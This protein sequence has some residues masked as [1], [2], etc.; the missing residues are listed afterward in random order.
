VTDGNGRYLTL[1]QI[2]DRWGLK[3]SW[4]HERSRRDELPGQ[5]RIGRRLIRVDVETFDAA[6]QEGLLR[7]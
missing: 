2:A 3:L 1:S 7:D 4:L 5:H 6:V